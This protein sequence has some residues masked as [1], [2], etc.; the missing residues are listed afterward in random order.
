MKSKKRGKNIRLYKTH[1]ILAIILFIILLLIFSSFFLNNNYSDSHKFNENTAFS[2]IVLPD[3]QYYSKNYPQIFLNQT[4]WISENK[5]NLNIRFI[6]HEG[7]IVNDNTL[8]QWNIANQ[9]LSILEDQNIPYSII[10][11]NHDSNNKQDYSY[12]NLFFPKERFETKDWY[13]GSFDNYKNNYQLLTIEN[14]SFIFLNLN[15]CPNN[16]EINWANRVLTN[17]SNKIAILTTHGFLSDNEPPERY[18]FFCGSTEYIWNNLIKSHPNLQ[19]VLSGHMHNE[20]RR[21]DNNI[22]NKPV[23]Q[24][25]ADFQDENQGGSGYLRIL[26]W[27]QETNVINVQTYSPYLNRYKKDYDSEFSLKL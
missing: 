19:L 26:N 21:V 16:E 22:A 5:E 9:S 1:I 12:Y 6:I 2:I 11:G 23:H 10:P 20:K 7:D 8:K 25:L 4:R 13:G 18:I 3:T 14:K 17:N 27:N 15:F 24:L